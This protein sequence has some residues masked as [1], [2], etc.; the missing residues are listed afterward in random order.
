MSNSIKVFRD[1]IYNLISFNKK[2][3]K[4]I[5]DIIDTPEFQ[6]LKRIKQLGLSSY[7]YPSS[8]HDRFSH[9]LGVCYIVGILFD[10]LKV[11]DK[12]KITTN[13][14]DNKLIEVELTKD[15]LRLVIRLAGLL[16]DIGHGPFSHAFEKVT[17]ID[18]EEMSIKIISSS[19]G[20][21]SKLLN[22]QID[23]VLA[24]YSKNIIIEILSGTF[25]PIWVKEL[26][27]SQLDA[28]RIDYLLRDAYMCGVSYAS[29]DYKWLFQ[30]IEIAQIST[31]Q[32]EGLVINASKGIHAVEAFILSRYH[33]YE[34]VYFHKTTRG[35]EVVVQ[36]IFERLAQLIKIGGLN[37]HFF[38]NYNLQQF[39]LDNS[40]LSSYLELDDYYLITQF[41][42]WI[43]G[44]FDEMLTKLCKI[45]INR[46][47]LKLIKEVKNDNLWSYHAFEQIINF[48]GENKVFY[49]ED[50]YNNVAYKDYYLLG[51]KS[52]EYA[53]H[54]WLKYDNDEQKELSQV[55]PIVKSLSNIE[56]K[57]YR[58]YV[59]RELYTDELKKNIKLWN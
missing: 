23:Q 50:D 34:Q 7:T 46:Q 56:L 19:D 55:S 13:S 9:S 14:I 6:R 29:F 45:I 10:N 21:I 25:K 51:K 40:N 39:M 41:N 33:M 24:V 54:I 17:N 42:H 49:F 47:P 3:E 32:R 26:I 16:H 48:L 1:P 43:I 18:H 59:Y 15:Q 28:D 12:I 22:N 20:T 31:E 57:K 8:V 35:F 52:S 2:E 5:L 30:N 27:S 53:E 36:G 37:E 4:I 44:N 58:A 38:I 11:L